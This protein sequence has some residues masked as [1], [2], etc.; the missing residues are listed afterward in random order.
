[1]VG[2]LNGH[3]NLGLLL[4]EKIDALIGSRRQLREA[5]DNASFDKE[6]LSRMDCR[7]LSELAQKVYTLASVSGGTQKVTEKIL[8]DV[9]GILKIHQ[10]RMNEE[11]RGA[12]AAQ[13][14]E[15]LHR[16]GQVLVVAE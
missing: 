1:V 8:E 3:T 6:L 15:R 4:G 11:E 2:V 16:I 5:F 13:I 12:L 7:N 9:S 10:F 14:Y